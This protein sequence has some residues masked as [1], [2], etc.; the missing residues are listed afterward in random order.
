MLEGEPG[1][2]LITQRPTTASL[3]LLWEFPG[4]RVMEGESDRDA[5]TRELRERLGV[6]V[7]V[8]EEAASTRHEY[9]DYDIEFHVYY[10][11]LHQ[12]GAPLR[13]L[14]AAD[15]RWVTLAEMGGYQFPGA[16]ART[17]ARLLELDH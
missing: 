1:R 10:C 11:R 17:L 15:H 12:P 8:L 4:G 5:L 14:R 3:P 7:D 6:E 2:Y 13:N 9:P 16:D